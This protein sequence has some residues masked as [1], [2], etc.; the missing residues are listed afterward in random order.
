VE[1]GR[2]GAGGRQ[3]GARRLS[4][5]TS[6]LGRRRRTLSP[7]C[8]TSKIR[9]RL[10][11]LL[12]TLA[13]SRSRNLSVASKGTLT[14]REP[15][16]SLAGGGERGAGSGE[17][18]VEV[19]RGGGRWV[20]RVSQRSRCAKPRLSEILDG[21]GSP[22]PAPHPGAERRNSRGIGDH[23]VSERWLRASATSR[24]AEIAQSARPLKGNTV[25]AHSRSPVPR[26]H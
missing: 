26:T 6:G 18:G 16:A 1:R 22:C 2:S 5:R 17:R 13:L 10:S 21:G 20:V 25:S 19:E 9:S 14:F 4:R 8:C 24:S 23:M 12:S 7:R 11:R 3:A 15:R